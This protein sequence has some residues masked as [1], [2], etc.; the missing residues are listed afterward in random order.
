MTALSWNNQKVFS[1]G[2]I[3]G[4]FGL[5]VD[6]LNDIFRDNRPYFI[7][8]VD[9][10][11]LINTDVQ[12]FKNQLEKDDKLQPAICIFLFTESGVKKLIALSQEANK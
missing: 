9:F 11:K 4:F 10:F 8:G 1:S 6:E 12:Q 2:Q 5:S 7:Q 3:V